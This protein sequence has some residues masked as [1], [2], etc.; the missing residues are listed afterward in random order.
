MYRP[1]Y[2]RLR[3]NHSQPLGEYGERRLIDVATVQRL[4]RDET[5]PDRVEYAL[6]AALI[7]L[8][9]ITTMTKLATGLN[10]AFTAIS[11]DL[12]SSVK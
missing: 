10:M 9:A 12:S 5:G 7:A 8:G 2:R 1:T 6:M 11:F 4:L 3:T